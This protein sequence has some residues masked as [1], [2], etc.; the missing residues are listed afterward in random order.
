M[1]KLFAQLMKFGLVGAL[2]TIIDFVVLIALTELLGLNPVLST[3]ISFVV[4]VLFNYA[5]SMK[6]VFTRREELSRKKELAI[7]VLLSVIGLGINDLLMWIGT[8]LLGAN[9]ILVKVVAT[10]IVMIW[11]FVSRK[12]FLEAKED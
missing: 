1:K 2:A 10:A 8:A 4:S 12:V 3:T 7:F 11:N 9:Y 6:Y 5:A